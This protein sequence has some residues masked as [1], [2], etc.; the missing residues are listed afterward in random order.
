ME[1][2]TFEMSEL[3]SGK[4]KSWLR[5]KLKENDKMNLVTHSEC[6][7]RDGKIRSVLIFEEPLMG[8]VNHIENMD[9]LLGEEDEK[10]ADIPPV[11]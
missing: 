2:F 5:K 11:S 10:D 7:A 1:R 8:L 4:V 6:V 9:S 3:P